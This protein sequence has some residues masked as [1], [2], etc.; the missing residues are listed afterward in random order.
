MPGDGQDLRAFA[1]GDLR[2]I[3][4]PVDNTVFLRVFDNP[5]GSLVEARIVVPATLFTVVPSGRAGARRDPGRG[6]RARG[7]GQR[8]PGRCIGS[9]RRGGRQGL[10]GRLRRRAG[11]SGCGAECERLDGLLAEAGDR[12]G[13]E[14]LTLDDADLYFGILESAR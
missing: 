1:H 13:D 9:V 14:E 5:A 4:E 8:R 2:G 7:R 11:R 3:V 6:G 12:S 10:R